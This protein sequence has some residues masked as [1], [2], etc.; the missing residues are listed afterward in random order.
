MV[1]RVRILLLPPSCHVTDLITDRVELTNQRLRDEFEMPGSVYITA[2][3][4]V[5]A[6]LVVFVSG[7]LFVLSP[8]FL[9]CRKL[10]G[11]TTFGAT[12][13]LVLSAACH[14]PRPASHIKSRSL[15][16]VLGIL[17]H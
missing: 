14:V 12:N 4:S 2:G 15:A 3:Y 11:D 9:S 16:Q 6:I 5:A 17:T 7:T 13:C 1:P 10:K 8:L